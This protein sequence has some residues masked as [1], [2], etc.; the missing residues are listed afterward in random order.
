MSLAALRSA[1][2]F[3]WPYSS[4]LRARRHPL[5]HLPR[6]HRPPPLPRVP[7]AAPSAS[8]GDAWLI[9]SRATEPTLRVILDSTLEEVTELPV[10]APDATWGHVLTATPGDQT[11]V[12]HNLVVQPGF[13]G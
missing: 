12:I 5:R 13:G 1:G 11:T 4:S 10:G 6:H 3:H 2:S 9:V 8:A 7:T